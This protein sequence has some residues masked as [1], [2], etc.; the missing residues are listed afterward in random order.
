MLG[1][2]NN[3]FLIN[4]F[5]N[6]DSS[7]TKLDVGLGWIGIGIGLTFEGTFRIGITILIKF[8]IIKINRVLVD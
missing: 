7:L 4:E 5:C 2:M 6:Y 1:V 3:Y 8:Y